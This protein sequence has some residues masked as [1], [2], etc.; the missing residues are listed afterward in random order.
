MKQLVIALKG[1]MV[2]ARRDFLLHIQEIVD[3][4]PALRVE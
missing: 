1:V 2:A 4:D 3:P